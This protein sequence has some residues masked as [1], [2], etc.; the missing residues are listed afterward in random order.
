MQNVAW[1]EI[2]IIFLLDDFP[3]ISFWG[4]W[5]VG[6][7]FLMFLKLFHDDSDSISVQSTKIIYN[8]ITAFS[9]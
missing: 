3:M 1:I 6:N 4:D 2:Q 5:K 7:L 8:L 9:P